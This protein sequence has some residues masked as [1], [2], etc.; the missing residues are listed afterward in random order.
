MSQCFFCSLPILTG[1]TVNH[2]HIVYKSRGG[3]D[4]AP[5]HQSCH[6]A[7]HSDQGDF[8]AW[9]RE[10]GKLTAATRVWAFNLK[11]VRSNPA[12]EMDRQY[13]RALYARA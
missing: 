4:T 13:Y 11:N 3:R 5:A 9:G 10:G 7:H 2:H 12:F 1:Q 6:R 8:K